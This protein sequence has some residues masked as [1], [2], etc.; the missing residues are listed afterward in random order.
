[1]NI[2]ENLKIMGVSP[3]IFWAIVG[4]VFALAVFL[5]YI[6]RNGMTVRLPLFLMFSSFLGVFPGARIFSYIASKIYYANTGKESYGGLVFYGGLLGFLTVFY[7]LQ[8]ISVNSQSKVLWDG[9]ALAIPLFHTFGRIGCA[10]S[11][12]CF[13][14]EFDKFYIA[15]SDGIKRF[16]V[17]FSE[18]F[19]EFLL[20][21]VLMIFACKGKYHGSLIKIYLF[22][23]SVLR[24]FL[25]FLRGDEIRGMIGCL[26]FS[27][28]C[29]IAVLAGLIIHSLKR[30][31]DT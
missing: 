1:M 11:G 5:Y 2:P 30:R 4:C 6:K 7:L 28:V 13:G 9:A 23:Y 31:S 10:F 8:K 29:S 26:S 15:Y 21:S 25:E 24:F 22:T 20:F 14:I 16:P 12:C 17:Q 18:A 19:S 27:Q 3:Y